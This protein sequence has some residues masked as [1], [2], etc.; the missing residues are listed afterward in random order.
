[1]K[2]NNTDRIS[3]LREFVQLLA[4]G[5][6]ESLEDVSRMAEACLMR[7]DAARAQED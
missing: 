1:M 5:G 6:G 4:D 7:D 2:T 3:N